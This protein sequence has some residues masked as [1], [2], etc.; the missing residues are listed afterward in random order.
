MRK[1]EES[2]E[3]RRREQE[4]SQ[5]KVHTTPC[6]WCLP[7]FTDLVPRPFVMNGLGTRLYVHRHSHIAYDIP[8]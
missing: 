7:M 2:K 8:I 4:I 5:E 3:R 1:K 6:Y